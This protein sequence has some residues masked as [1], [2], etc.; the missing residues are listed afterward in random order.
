MASRVPVIVPVLV[1]LVIV[2]LLSMASP[3]VPVPVI[4][5]VLVNAS[6]VPPLK[7]P[8]AAEIVRLLVNVSTLPPKAL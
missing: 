2:P 5:L 1:N 8:T 7:I 3:E 4:V 6:T